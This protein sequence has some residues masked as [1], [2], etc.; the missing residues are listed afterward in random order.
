MATPKEYPLHRREVS[1]KKEEEPPHYLK[2]KFP[3]LPNEFTTQEKTCNQ[4]IDESE[5]IHS[6][7]GD[8]SIYKLW[9]SDMNLNMKS[10]I[11]SKLKSSK[12]KKNFL[13]IISVSSKAPKA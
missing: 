1:F 9:N 10:E 8:E 4:K 13:S 11:G 3:T 2:E 5:L 12:R 6:K 7:Q